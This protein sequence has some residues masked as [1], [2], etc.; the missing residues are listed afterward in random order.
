MSGNCGFLCLW[1]AVIH[2]QVTLRKLKRQVFEGV[3]RSREISH[4]FGGICEFTEAM[5]TKPK[6]FSCGQE[7]GN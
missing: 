3:K 1:S 2:S 6:Q 4:L 5:P 7:K